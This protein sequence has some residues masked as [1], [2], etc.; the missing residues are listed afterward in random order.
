MWEAN[1]QQQASA[2][3]AHSTANNKAPVYLKVKIGNRPCTCLLDAGCDATLIP[4]E[5]VR[6][7]S[8]ILKTDQQCIAANGTQIPIVGTM[9]IRATVGDF[10]IEI[11]G[12]VT[13]HVSTAMLGIDWLLDNDVIWN[14]NSGETELGGRTFRLLSRKIRQNWSRRVI[15]TGDTVVPPKIIARSDD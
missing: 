9:T 7:N 10:P 8:T 2:A 4:T 12:L 5:M 14:F 6:G 11:K 15:L 13:D 3:Q 1:D